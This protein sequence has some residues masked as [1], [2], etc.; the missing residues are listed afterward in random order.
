M[1]TMFCQDLSLSALRALEILS[2][3]PSAYMSLSE[4][5]DGSDEQS[6]ITFDSELLTSVML[7]IANM[8]H[9]REDAHKAAEICDIEFT[10]SSTGQ[11]L[12]ERARM[13]RYPS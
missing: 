6:N 5:S 8:M 1:R 11:E 7:R 4:S 10:K 13:V 3:W 9:L 12:Y 2:L